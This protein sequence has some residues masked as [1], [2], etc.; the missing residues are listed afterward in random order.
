MFFRYIHLLSFS[1]RFRKSQGSE[2]AQLNWTGNWIYDLT[3][4]LDSPND[5]NSS[6]ILKLH[7]FKNPKLRSQTLS[8]VEKK[9]HEYI[10]VFLSIEKNR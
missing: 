9:P 1:R 5:L 10:D 2:P 8:S 4:M 3:F 6:E 7:F